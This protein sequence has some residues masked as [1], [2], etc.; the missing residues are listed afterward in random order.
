[1]SHYTTQLRWPVEQAEESAT[2]T[3]ANGQQ[4]HVETYKKL[5]LDDY[6][7]FD[8]SYRHTLNDKIIRHFYFR[9]IGQETFNMFTWYMRT[10]MHEIMP[11]YN[12]L[13]ESTLL[14]LDPMYDIDMKY[15]ETWSVDKAGNEKSVGH[16][17]TT[18]HSKGDT[19][20][21]ASSD[22]RG[23]S[24]TQTSDNG[25]THNRN[26]YSDTPMSLLK[27]DESPTVEGLDYATNV[28]YDDGTSSNSGTSATQTTN[29]S[30]TTGKVGE[31]R[32]SSGDVDTTGN[33]DTTSDEDG[34]RDRY[35]KG[36]RQS[37]AE[38]L[39]KWRSTFLNIDVKIIADLEP[40]FMGVW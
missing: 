24:D 25:S 16:T 4:F 10:H 13:Y 11:Y 18:S 30:D 26:V 6:P 37:K 23:T 8:E 22:A 20:T 29:H 28:T 34:K 39:E 14:E 27:N 7:I 15:G 9:E 3:L 2:S 19:S 1:M 36:N 35:E 5:R 31:V 32:D 38:L 40:L 12:Q 21:S 17:G 33:V